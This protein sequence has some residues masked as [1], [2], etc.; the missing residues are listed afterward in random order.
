MKKGLTVANL[1]D[2]A[3]NAYG[4][5]I[6]AYRDEPAKYRFFGPEHDGITL[7]FRQGLEATCLIA[8]GLRRKLGVKRGDKIAVLLTNL[9]EIALFAQAAA[10]I[11]AIVVPFNFMLKAQEI[12]KLANDCD[13]KVLVTEP[14]L[15]NMNIKDKSKVPQVEHW[16]MVG[17]EEQIPEGFISLDELS[18]GMERYI[19]PIDLDPDEP[20]AIFYT[21][22]TTGF[23]KG[24]MLS[25][26]N[27]LSTT[28]RSIRLLRIGKKD[29]GITALPM[30]H[31]FGFNTT[32]VGGL[33]A[34]ST[35]LIMRFF[36]PEKVL[37]SIEK[38]K[39][40]IFVGVP[41]MYNLLLLAHPE[42][43]D[44]SSMRYWLSGAD[45]MP[46]EQIKVFEALGGKFIEGYGL[47]ETSPIVSVNLPLPFLRR[48]GSIGLPLPGVKV[49]IMDEE[50]NILPRGKV[51]EIV[52]RGPNV[53]KGYWNDEKA[54]AEAFKF[55][56]F[57]TGDMGYRDRLGFIYFVDREKDVIKVGGY[58]VFSCEV[59]E[60]ILQNPKVLKAALVGIPH[61]TKGQVPVAVVQL[62]DGETATE[63]ELLE[64]CKE[65][66]AAYKAPRKI[67][68]VK[69]MPLTM[70]L[71]VLK[72]ELRKQ[73]ESQEQSTSG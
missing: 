23:P 1:I 29:F 37:H 30:A 46:V 45:A 34:G 69:E 59:E 38:Y 72:R 16:I 66:I 53:M 50:G 71:K 70:T 19:E 35:G 10:R 57:H 3:A 11:G 36:D 7:T 4:D 54:T 62:K 18:E 44:L 43:Y 21:S 63:E 67:K 2:K 32:I 56:W 25:S 51:G 24:A 17:P 64:W 8:D 39:A 6:C 31:I 26:K 15:F 12:M 52:V 55:G 49:R 9:P 5:R 58:T 20:V 41:A 47:A 33:Y 65:H 13:A 22:G 28:R 27:L 68:I 48:P 61:P 14:Q 73:F 40:T 60:E 42:K